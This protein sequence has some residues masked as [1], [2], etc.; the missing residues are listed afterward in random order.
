VIQKTPPLQGSNFL[1]VLR[2]VFGHPLPNNLRIWRPDFLKNPQGLHPKVAG[3][4]ILARRQKSHTE[5]CKA[6]SLAVPV[7]DFQF[8]LQRLFVK[9]D[10]F[11]VVT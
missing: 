4:R 11:L 3:P 6:N 2:T 7:A 8:D 5:I 9:L 10:G 1:R